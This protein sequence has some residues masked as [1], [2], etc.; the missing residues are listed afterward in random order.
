MP[1]ASRSCLDSRRSEA[2]PELLVLRLVG[3]W[4][5]ESGSAGPGTRDPGP[6]R[7]RHAAAAAVTVTVTVL[8]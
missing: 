7:H 3:R 4:T 6:G 8:R 2:V 5:P 1:P